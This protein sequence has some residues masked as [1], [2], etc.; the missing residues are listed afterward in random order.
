MKKNMGHSFQG[1]LLAGIFSF[2]QASGEGLTQDMSTIN[3]IPVE[4]S[5]Q[6]VSG[7]TP[8]TGN[9]I[10]ENRLFNYPPDYM[11]REPVLN[12]PELTMFNFGNT[13]KMPTMASID[14]RGI[15]INHWHDLH[16]GNL[17]YDKAGNEY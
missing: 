7:D 8:M 15:L 1:V 9:S 12:Y 4:T 13:V 14:E 10:V 2:I 6:G 16:P 11:R 3:A 17:N 5:V